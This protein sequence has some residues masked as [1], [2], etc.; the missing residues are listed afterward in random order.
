VPTISVEIGP[1]LARFYTGL[2]AVQKRTMDEYVVNL[3]RET[4]TSIIEQLTPS[5]VTVEN[6]E[7]KPM[8]PGK[9]SYA[10]AVTVC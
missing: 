9:P 2:A 3:L 8:R 7:T 10:G 1:G 5:V 6:F 4:A